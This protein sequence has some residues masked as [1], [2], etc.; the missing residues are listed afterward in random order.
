MLDALL[1]LELGVDSGSCSSCENVSLFL[2]IPDV[3]LTCGSGWIKTSFL[4]R[5]RSWATRPSSKGTPA[6]SRL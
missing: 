1:C 2:D 5:I 3:L 6:P 4:R